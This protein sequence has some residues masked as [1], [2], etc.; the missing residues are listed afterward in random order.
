M[1]FFFCES[2]VYLVFGDISSQCMVVVRLVHPVVLDGKCI[3]LNSVI[4]YVLVFSFFF[5]CNKYYFL[6]A[7]T[8]I[9]TILF[10]VKK[11]L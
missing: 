4:V 5:Y 1:Y 11:Q 2:A 3:T 6:V 8:S 7:Y 10:A 9:V